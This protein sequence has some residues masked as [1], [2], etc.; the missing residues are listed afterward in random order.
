VTEHLIALPLTAWL[1]VVV[2]QTQQEFNIVPRVKQIDTVAAEFPA[3]N[4]YL[5][6]TYNGTEDDIETPGA[7]VVDPLVVPAGKADETERAIIVLGSG[8]YCIGS[9]VE[10]DYCA[11]RCAQTLK[12]LGVRSIHP[13][14]HPICS[15][16]AFHGE[17]CVAHLLSHT[18][19]QKK[20]IM[21]NYNPETVSTD[22][23]ECDKLYFEELSFER[24]VDIY[25]SEQAAG[26]VVSMG[27]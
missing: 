24:V 12:K 26:V 3:Y 21:I 9:S 4:N 27:T 19:P 16:G 13:S 8:A 18:H 17:G 15:V 6:I 7:A 10:F 14:I 11:V 23:D 25:E 1:S 2:S 5:Y 20:T 22:Y